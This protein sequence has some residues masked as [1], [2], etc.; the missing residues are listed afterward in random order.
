M[1]YFSFCRKQWCRHKRFTLSVLCSIMLS[2]TCIGTVI[3]HPQI[4]FY[5]KY[6]YLNL[7]LRTREAV[8]QGQANKLLCEV[9][10]RLQLSSIYD[11]DSQMTVY[12][13]DDSWVRSLC[14]L[15]EPKA[16]GLYYYGMKHVFLSGADFNE[17][18]LI[19]NRNIKIT[20]QRDLAYFITHELTHLVTLRETGYFSYLFMHNWIREGYADYVGRGSAWNENNCNAF[21][22]DATSMHWPAPAPYLRYNLLV[23]FELEREGLSLVELFNGN[24]PQ[25]DIE[26]RLYS[27]LQP[28]R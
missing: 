4:L 10:N 11:P 18:R 1:S 26:N 5:Y 24:Q 23:A 20:D 7:T 27:Y 9:V 25:K 15:P 6:E 2:V 21:V 22:E 14:F 19:N 8:P 3:S 16:G 13:C 12:I 28:T 17:L